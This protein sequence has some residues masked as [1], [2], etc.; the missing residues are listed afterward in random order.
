MGAF[1]VTGSCCV[2]RNFDEVGGVSFISASI[3]LIELIVG[4][5]ML[6]LEE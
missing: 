2:E 1:L 6:S 5:F 4:K 3:F